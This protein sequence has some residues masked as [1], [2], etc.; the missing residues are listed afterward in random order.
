MNTGPKLRVLARVEV[1]RLRIAAR[2]AALRVVWFG[3]AAMLGVLAVGMLTL[4]AFLALTPI[5]GPAIAALITGG[6]LVVLAAI[7]VLIGGRIDGGKEA[8]MAR[9]IERMAMSELQTDLAHAEAR[10]TAF[11]DEVRTLTSPQ[12]AG[13]L[14]DLAARALSRFL[15]RFLRRLF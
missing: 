10:L 3:L 14:G 7:A 6:G 2:V 11:T 9:E 4:S 15:G 5:F 13:R 1:L 8:A 12:G